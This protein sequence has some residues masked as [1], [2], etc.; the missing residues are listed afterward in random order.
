MGARRLPVLS[1]LLLVICLDFPS[2]AEA[3][4]K[5]RKKRKEE[6][7]GEDRGVFD[8]VLHDDEAWKQTMTPLHVEAQRGLV[9]NVR[10][11]LTEEGTARGDAAKII[12]KKDGRKWTPLHHA[13]A[14]GHSYLQLVRVRL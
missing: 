3:K 5:K 13:A 6:D 10:K 4:K 8:A 7:E 14:Q 1:L 11:L 12:N 9:Y 2:G